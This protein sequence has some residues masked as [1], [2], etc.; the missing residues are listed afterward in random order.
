MSA[1][2]RRKTTFGIVYDYNTDIPIVYS[3]RGLR[4][5]QVL[6]P[7]DIGKKHSVIFIISI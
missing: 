7:F 3:N 1:P 6:F 2:F 5:F 4:G